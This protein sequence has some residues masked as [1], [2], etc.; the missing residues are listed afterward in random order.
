MG[1]PRHAPQIRGG[2]PRYSLDAADAGAW[3]ARV[4][5]RGSGVAAQAP[6]NAM[7]TVATAMEGR[8][9]GMDPR[10][11]ERFPLGRDRA[12]CDRA[13]GPGASARW[14]P[15]RSSL[16]SRCLEVAVRA[17]SAPAS[18]MAPASSNGLHV[19]LLHPQSTSHG[20]GHDASAPHGV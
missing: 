4:T 7:E 9:A 3:G 6:T 11:H 18:A 12:R 16:G 17:Q 20:G 5:K 10:R 1:R 15:P 13:R 2:S 19:Q 14:L 8:I